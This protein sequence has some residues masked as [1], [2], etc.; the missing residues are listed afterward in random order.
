MQTDLV[1]SGLCESLKARHV[2]RFFVS[3][4]NCGIVV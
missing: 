3:E 2:A 4:A 1:S